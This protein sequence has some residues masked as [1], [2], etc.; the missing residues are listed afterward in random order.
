MKNIGGRRCKIGADLFEIHEDLPRNNTTHK[1]TPTSPPL[2]A[3]QRASAQRREIQ[4]A[5]RRRRN[6]A[7]A[8]V[9]RFINQLT[10]PRV[11]S[12]RLHLFSR[13]ILSEFSARLNLEAE[14]GK[15]S[16][17]LPLRAG[18]SGRPP[19]PPPPILPP[20]CST[21]QDPR[22]GSERA[23]SHDGGKGNR[24]HHHHHH[25]QQPQQQVR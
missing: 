22:G 19:R 23:A 9:V 17:A 12:A 7:P 8:L 5:A 1:N 10:G 16:M 3:Y 6:T 20:P 15:G 24:R 18:E 25:Q 14:Q 2:V 4:L 21:S 13:A 11:V